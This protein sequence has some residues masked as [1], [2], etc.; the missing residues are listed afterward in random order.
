M[1]RVVIGRQR[2]TQ[3]TRSAGERRVADPPSRGPPLLPPTWFVSH[4]TEVRST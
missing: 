3:N 1:R 2:S 4:V